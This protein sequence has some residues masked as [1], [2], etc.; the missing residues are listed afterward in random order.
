MN[1]DEDIDLSVG[2]KTVKQG[3]RSSKID[4][5]EE[6][7]SPR[8]VPVKTGVWTDEGTKSNKNKGPNVIEQER[9]QK[10]KIESDDDIPV[11][12]DID[13]LQDD[14]LNLPDVRPMVTVDKS[15]YKELDDQFENL[16]SDQL[17]F[18][19]VGDVDL[20]FFTSKLYN[21]KSVEESN[22]IWTMESLF[23]DLMR[24]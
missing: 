16:Q 12:P 8:D 3:R 9:F 7:G 6:A 13:D 20:S 19:S 1:W 22:E 17:N 5:P 21:E 11:I 18:G 14:P 23:E 15:T 2:K 4:S 24:M 10:E